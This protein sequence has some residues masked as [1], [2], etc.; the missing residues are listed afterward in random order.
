MSV[1]FALGV[2]IRAR[3]ELSNVDIFFFHSSI[4]IF[5]G[6]DWRA[7]PTRISVCILQPLKT[8]PTIE[9]KHTHTCLLAEPESVQQELKTECMQNGKELCTEK[10]EV[11]QMNEWRKKNW[12]KKTAL[13]WHCVASKNHYRLWATLCSILLAFCL[14]LLLTHVRT[15]RERERKS[16]VSAVNRPNLIWFIFRTEHQEQKKSTRNAIEGIGRNI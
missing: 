8:M 4:Y 3:V 13:A 11:K 1:S 15:E 14:P 12:S 7:S 2:V 5:F 6:G 16:S 10:P 9:K